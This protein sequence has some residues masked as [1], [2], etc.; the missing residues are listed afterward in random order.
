MAKNEAWD[1]TRLDPFG[2]A[3]KARSFRVISNDSPLDGHG[4]LR[5]QPNAYTLND[6]AVTQYDRPT[7]ASTALTG[8]D[9]EYASRPALS[10]S[11]LTNKALARFQGRLNDGKASLGITI[12][13]WKQSRD[14]IVD[15][16]DK[17]SKYFDGRYRSLRRRGKK[18]RLG[19]SASANLEAQFGWWPL[20]TD[21]ATASTSAFT[22]AI[23][24][25]HV[26]GR[27][28]E[29]FDFTV[30]RGNLGTGRY[31]VQYVGRR[32]V[33]VDAF[34][35]IT[36]P[37]LW[38]A[39]RMG[40]VNPPSVTWDAI[41]W[42]W[43]VGMFVNVNQILNQFSDELGLAVEKRSITRKLTYMAYI[44]VER[45]G[46]PTTTLS[47]LGREKLRTVGNIPAVTIQFRM[48]SLD[49]NLVGIATSLVV[50]RVKKWRNLQTL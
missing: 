6:Y 1:V 39:Q 50:Q 26:S 31:T 28:S 16:A 7:Q 27:A 18:F 45:R 48:P 41:P 36:N 25:L 21:L 49:W 38:L 22:A 20:V 23:P 9:S 33:C 44:K 14:M 19:D 24:P 2:T 30:V 40:V 8:V 17:L 15:R 29:K 47:Y 46:Y 37:N 34:V 4:N 3:F 11:A 35:R 43:V 13:Q 42:S 12:A 10:D 5:L 32:T